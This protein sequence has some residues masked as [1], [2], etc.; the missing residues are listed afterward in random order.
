MAGS[1]RLGVIRVAQTKVRRKASRVTTKRT[2]KAVLSEAKKIFPRDPGAEAR[3][4]A[5]KST[6]K[7]G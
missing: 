3:R 7:G 2:T 6:A 5:R 1:D 4:L